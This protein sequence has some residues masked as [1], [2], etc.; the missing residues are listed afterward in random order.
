MYIA[1]LVAIYKTSGIPPIFVVF[2][3][4]I[5]L[6]AAFFFLFG[7]VM[8][9]NL[10]GFAY[11][12]YAS[13]KAIKSEG[14]DDDTQWLTYWVVYAFFNVLET[15]IDSIV[16]YFPQYFAFKI[17]LLFWMFSPTTMGADFTYKNFLRPYLLEHEAT[18]D[19]YKNKID[20][21]VTE[22]VEASH[23]VVHELEELVHHTIQAATHHEHHQVEQTPIEDAAPTE[24]P[25]VESPATEEPPAAVEEEVVP[26][27]SLAEEVV[28]VTEPPA[29]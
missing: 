4:S 19:K 18:F 10:V 7:M 28:A 2:A 5:V 20:N 16:I 23:E 8:L 24:Q 9:C 3:G 26:A 14:K 22:G 25:A 11:P 1:P 6:A 17:G 12:A 13:Y 27:P 29:E 15:F 21:A